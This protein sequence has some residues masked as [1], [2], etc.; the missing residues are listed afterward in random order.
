MNIRT[1]LAIE[2]LEKYKQAFGIENSEKIIGNIK[3]NRVGVKNDIGAKKIGKPIGEYVTIEMPNLTDY[4]RCTDERIKILSEELKHF[5]KNQGLTLV[6]GLGNP[7]IT[8]DALGPKVINNILATRHISKEILN[9]TGLTQ[10]NP[11]AAVALNVL[12]KT[13]IESKELLLSIVQ[14]IKPTT[15]IIIDAMASRSLS[16]L[17]CTI[18]ISDTGICPGAG[19]GNSR[20]E[21]NQKVLGIP[22]ISIGVPTVVDAITMVEDVIG[23][24]NINKKIEEKLNPNGNIMIITPREIDLL[25]HRASL[26]ISMGINCALQPNFSA[27]DLHS[28]VF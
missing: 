12:G 11:V 16:R 14:R 2:L 7:D 8:P 3:I 15:L 21:I 6:V 25:I 17:G 28:L 5:I 22:V 23:E 26:L 10:L 20:P 13:G 27:E 18:Q 24:Q 19:V 4:L 9:A 1:D